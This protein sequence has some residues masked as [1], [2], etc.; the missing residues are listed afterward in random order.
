MGSGGC[1]KFHLIES[2]FHSVSKALLYRRRDTVKPRVFLIALTG[3]AAININRTTI[4]PALH[5]PCR[6]SFLPLNDKNKA[7]LRKRYSEVGL[8]SI[9]KISIL[10]NKLLY[11]IRKLVNEIFTSTQDTRV[12]GKPDDRYQ[13]SSVQAKSVFVFDKI[14]TTEGFISRDLWWELQL[15]E[16]YYQVMR[17]KDDKMFA[18]LLNKIKIDEIDENIE[19]VLKPRFIQKM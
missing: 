15:S 1:G 6:P 3:V 11:H 8:V 13:I 18:D 12:G 2:V 7:E 19:I 9:D 4:H 17:Q 5:I 14:E 16:L 10:S